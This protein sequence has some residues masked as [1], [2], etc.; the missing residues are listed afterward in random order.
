MN[1]NVMDYLGRKSIEETF[2]SIDCKRSKASE[3][4][5]WDT[6]RKKSLE[7]A[8]EGT[9]TF[10]NHVPFIIDNNYFQN[11]ILVHITLD[12]NEIGADEILLPQGT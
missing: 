7:S 2:G 10:V 5:A 8:K 9:I 4:E 3:T 11:K 12:D 6:L 1:S